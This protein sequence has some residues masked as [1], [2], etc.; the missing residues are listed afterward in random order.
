MGPRRAGGTGFA[1][2]FGLSANPIASTR[3][4]FPD[5]R[6]VIDQMVVEGDLSRLVGTARA[7]HGQDTLN[8]TDGRPVAPS[9]ITPASSEVCTAPVL[10]VARAV[11]VWVPSVATHR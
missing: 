6:T 10:S 1:V 4:A 2:E 7:P 5:L 3:T 9:G 8:D 11:I